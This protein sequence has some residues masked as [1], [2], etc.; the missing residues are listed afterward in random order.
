[1]YRLFTGPARILGVHEG[2]RNC[3]GFEGQQDT[4]ERGTPGFITN[5]ATGREAPIG[6][7]EIELMRCFLIIN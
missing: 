7:L 1:M 2:K 5:A 3:K 4:V 6:A